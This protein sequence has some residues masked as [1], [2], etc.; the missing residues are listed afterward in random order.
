M[1][2]TRKRAPAVSDT[3]PRRVAVYCRVSTE[4]ELQEGSFELQMRHYRAL[5][6]ADPRMELA[7]LY[8]D[9]GKSGSH[10]CIGIICV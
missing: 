2:D 3:A 8:G 5:V 10:L 7:G 4:M 1:D 6:E 9:R